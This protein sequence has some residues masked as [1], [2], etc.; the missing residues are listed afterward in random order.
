MHFDVGEDSYLKVHLPIPSNF[1]IVNSSL[2]IPSWSTKSKSWMRMESFVFHK[3][4][5]QAP[6]KVSAGI[7]TI[8][9]WRSKEDE[10]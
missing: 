7:T 6:D 2:E 10:D 8:L 5:S 9:R 3:G 4:K 1:I